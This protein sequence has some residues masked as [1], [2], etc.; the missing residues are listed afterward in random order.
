MSPESD[1]LID[2]IAQAE[3][4]P[5]PYLITGPQAAYIYHGW[6]HPVPKIVDVCIPSLEGGKAAWQAAL[7][8]PWTVLAQT[9]TLSQARLASRIV[10]LEPC[11]TEKRYER[12]VMYQGLAFISA[13]DLCIDLLHNSKTQIGLAEIAA[14]LIKQK[15]NLD[16]SYLLDETGSSWLGHRLLEIVA[17]VNHEAGRVLLETQSLETQ[18]AP[19]SNIASIHPGTLKEVLRPLRAQWEA[20]NA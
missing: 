8:P 20:A 18:I 19:P 12:R 1:A 16:W 2:L 9:P 5:E 11:L 7:R 4:L 6:L 13:E 3:A 10:V 14:L 17:M 15:D